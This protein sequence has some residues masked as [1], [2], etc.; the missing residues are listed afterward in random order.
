MCNR[1]YQYPITNAVIANN[2]IVVRALLDH[3]ANVEVVDNEGHT[4]VHYA[5]GRYSN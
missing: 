4:L 5:A 1:N 2:Q 3:N